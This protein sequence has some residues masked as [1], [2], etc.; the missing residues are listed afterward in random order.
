MSA[1]IPEDV[2]ALQADQVPWN[3][4]HWHPAHGGL[5]RNVRL[6][7]T[8]PLHISLPLYSF[9]DTAGP[10]V[11]ATDIAPGSARVGLEVPI[12]NGRTRRED[13]ELLAEVLDASGAPVLTLRHREA[14]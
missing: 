14:V 2:G 5:Y 8:D 9:L 13:V 10:Y 11:Y 3:N 6:H 7:L 12:E 4:P 1:E